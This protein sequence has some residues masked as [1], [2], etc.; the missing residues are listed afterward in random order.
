MGVPRI[1]LLGLFPALDLVYVDRGFYPVWHGPTTVSDLVGGCYSPVQPGMTYTLFWLLCNPVG[2][3]A[4]PSLACPQTQPAQVLE[5]AAAL[6]DLI[7]TQPQ[8]QYSPG[9][10]MG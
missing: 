7:H 5:S 9:G 10:A 3:K 2:A 1:L 4:L 8:L 6:P